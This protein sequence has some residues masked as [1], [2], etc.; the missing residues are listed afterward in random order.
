ML[1]A[2]GIGGVQLWNDRE[3]SQHE[4]ALQLPSGSAGLLVASDGQIVSAAPL[5]SRAHCTVGNMLA[6]QHACT[7]QWVSDLQLASECT[8]LALAHIPLPACLGCGCRTAARLLLH[9]WRSAIA[10]Q[11]A[12]A[13]SRRCWMSQCSSCSAARAQRRRWRWSLMHAG[14]QLSSRL[15]PPPQCATQGH[16]NYSFSKPGVET[17]SVGAA[18]PLATART[19]AQLP[20]SVCCLTT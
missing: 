19:L 9:C 5:L 20:P 14:A 13:A 8:A 6:G 1:E 16:I 3:L 10:S 2:Q 18:S 11:A 12:A 17:P 4:R 7:S 15:P